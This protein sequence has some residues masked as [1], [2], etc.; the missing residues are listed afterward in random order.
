MFLWVKRY[1]KDKDGKLNIREFL[2]A[3]LPLDSNI[4]ENAKQ[5]A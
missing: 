2:T 5:R 1:D 3:L 4:S